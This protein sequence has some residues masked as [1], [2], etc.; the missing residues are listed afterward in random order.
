MS[1]QPV[2]IAAALPK[3]DKQQAP[4][5][6]VQGGLRFLG[7]LAQTLSDRKATEQLVESITEKDEKT[8]RTYVKL[9]VDDVDVVHQFF[10]ALGG[11][12]KGGR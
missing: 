1:P 4:Q 7:R 10:Q 3:Q 8:G 11:L 6:L 5:D 12:L 2:H 9:P